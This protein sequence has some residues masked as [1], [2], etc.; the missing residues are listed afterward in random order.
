MQVKTRLP[1]DFEHEMGP[2]LPPKRRKLRPHPH[3]IKIQE[4]SQH[5]FS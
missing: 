1:T 3:D 4:K 5:Q 2:N